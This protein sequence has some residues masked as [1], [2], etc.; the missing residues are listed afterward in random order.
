MFRPSVHQPLTI[1]QELTEAIC[2]VL[3]LSV[4]QLLT[5]NQELTEAICA[6]LRPSVYQPLT[7]NQEL[8]ETICA[9]FRTF[10][11]ST[12]NIPSLH[13][14]TSPSARIFPVFHF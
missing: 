1:N 8:T 9:V 11:P 7:F 4:H 13:S 3:R 14:G 2:V 10:S 12:Y 6:V 5:F